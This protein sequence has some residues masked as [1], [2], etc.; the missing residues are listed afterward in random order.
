MFSI[1]TKYLSEIHPNMYKKLPCFLVIY[2]LTCSPVFAGFR[3][4]IL[5]GEAAYDKG[6]YSVALAYL[7]AAE[8]KSPRDLDA[9]YYRA[10]TLYYLGRKDEAARE[11][12]KCISIGHV[13][14]YVDSARQALQSL[15]PKYSPT[16]KSILQQGKAARTELLSA[17][18]KYASNELSNGQDAVAGI[19]QYEND[20]L[21]YPHLHQSFINDFQYD[22]DQKA[23]GVA[24]QSQINAQSATELANK[25][26]QAIKDTAH[27]LARQLA[28]PHSAGEPQVNPV[29]TNLYVRDY[30]LTSPAVHDKPTPQKANSASTNAA[31]Q[32]TANH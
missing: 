28:A 22:E 21:N 15:K 4:D 20:T 7:T 14:P 10:N 2:A 32:H 11:Y 29:G 26:A 17:G 8:S 6:W 27:E 19:R 31:Q 5:N 12:S 25:Q 3:S 18:Q 13:G 30:I 24:A 16:E 23:N 1:Y 9:I